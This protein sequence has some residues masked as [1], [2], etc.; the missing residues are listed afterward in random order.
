MK[1]IIPIAL[2]F[3]L[4]P[5]HVQ[6]GEPRLIGSYSDWDAYVFY[7]GDSKV[8]YMASKPKKDE[9][10]YSK[11][12]EIYALVTH[13]PAEGTKN[14]F[15]YIAGY[16]YKTGSDASVEVN[17][18]KFVL[19][20]QDDTGWAPDAETDGRIVDSI[21]KGSDMVVRGTSSRGTS[22]K[23]TF[24]L[25]GSSSAHDKITEECKF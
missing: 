13:R 17:G 22:T 2:L 12:G 11:R 6:A 9:G 10:D 20:T 25:K 5:F 19:F 8:C 3:I 16:T 1:Y 21:R 7:E 23:D 24:S 4:L 15:S 14:V 18:Q